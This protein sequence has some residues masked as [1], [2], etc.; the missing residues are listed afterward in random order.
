MGASTVMMRVDSIPQDE[1]DAMSSL[2]PD[3][4]ALAGLADD[5]T[6]LASLADNVEALTALAAKSTELLKLVED[7]VTPGA[8]V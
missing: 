3:A 8:E 5:A 4:T 1:W 6:A 7:E 2:A